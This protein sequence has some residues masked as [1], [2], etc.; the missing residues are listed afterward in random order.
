MHL[1][2]GPAV[3]L[4]LSAGSFLLSRSYLYMEETLGER[5]AE[6]RKN[7]G[8]NQSQAAKQKGVQAQTLSVSVK[9]AA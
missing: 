8:L 5:L 6:A 3:G 9:S 4:V 2:T 7:S 1:I